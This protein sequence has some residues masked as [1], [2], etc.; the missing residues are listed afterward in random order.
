MLRV[1]IGEIL[2]Y[3]VLKA[4]LKIMWG[5]SGAAARTGNFNKKTTK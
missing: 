4:S 1:N 3:V 2:D 5:L